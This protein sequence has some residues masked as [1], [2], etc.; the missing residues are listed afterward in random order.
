MNRKQSCLILIILL[1]STVIFTGAALAESKTERLLADFEA[2]YQNASV[3]QG[4]VASES[5]ELEVVLIVYKE[6]VVIDYLY[7]SIDEVDFTTPEG[8]LL[9]HISCVSEAWYSLN[10]GLDFQSSDDD[11]WLKVQIEKGEPFE[12]HIVAT[13]ELT[14]GG[15]DY[16]IFKR[17]RVFP[18]NPVATTAASL[19]GVYIVEKHDSRWKGTVVQIYSMLAYLGDAFWQLKTPIFA[20]MLT[21][22]FSTSVFEMD[23]LYNESLKH[24]GIDPKY[25]SDRLN[26]FGIDKVDFN[27]ADFLSTSHDAEFIEASAS[28]SRKTYEEFRQE[29][30]EAQRLHRKELER[31]FQEAR[32]QR[33]LE[34]N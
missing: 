9:S 2:G 25:L 20:D 12:D 27:L 8:M 26:N 30:V 17:F 18:E 10:W 6:P 24:G 32:E 19:P 34:S 31:K 1:L 5:E 14:Y 11:K 13:L 3:Y 16:V 28:S 21:G 33:D 22:E 15:I 29:R 4:T 23:Q 7:H